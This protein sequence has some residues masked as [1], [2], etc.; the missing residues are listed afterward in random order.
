MPERFSVLVYKLGIN[1]C[2]DVPE[3]VSKTFGIRGFVPVKGTLNGHRLQANLVPM[4]GGR[5]RL[6]LNGEMRVRAGVSV[7]DRVDI[8]LEVDREPRQAPVPARLAE[9]LAENPA[10]KAAFE[11]LTSSRR[12]EILDYLNW[13]K[14]PETL[15]RKINDVIAS[16]IRQELDDH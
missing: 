10:A 11:R 7:G 14:R 4:G 13:L 5:H 9:A 16:L 1:P 8:V 12:K 2:V 15:Q 3:E 6:Y